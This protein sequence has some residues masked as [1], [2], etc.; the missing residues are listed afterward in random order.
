MTNIASYYS[1][2]TRKLQRHYKHKICGFKEWNQL[3]HAEE[4]LIYP[5]NLTEHISID[6]VILSKGELYTFVTNKNTGVRNKNQLL[7]S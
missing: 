3:S 7:R 6:E 4:Y 2:N 1:L 5:E